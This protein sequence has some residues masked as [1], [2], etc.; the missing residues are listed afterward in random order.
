MSDNQEET[1]EFLRALPPF[2]GLDE[3]ALSE[4][5]GM[6]HKRSYAQGEIITLEGERCTNA[7]FVVS[8]Q[9]KMNK[10]SLEG[11]EQV[12]VRLGPG[13]A[14][15]LT[16]VFDGGPNPATGQAY[17]EVLLYA[18]RKEDFLDIVRR[19]P[20]VALAVLKHL[21]AKL[22]HFTGLVEELSLYTVEARLARLLL[23]LATEEDVVH[24][25][26]TQQEMAAELGTV[27]EVIGRALRDLGREGVIRLDRHRIVIVDKEALE[28]K[29]ML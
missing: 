5:A 22:R 29:A 8:G 14:F 20:D 1:I 12:M 25:R 15:C 4:I 24:R 11:R 7:Y 2:Q 10:V 16:P 6:A 9:V 23:R 19:Y 17:T 18:F 27:R 13:D 26:M 3:P 21:S 28:A